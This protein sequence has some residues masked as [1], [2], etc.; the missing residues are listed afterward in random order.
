MGWWYRI[1]AQCRLLPS[2]P[3][4]ICPTDCMEFDWQPEDSNHL[5]HFSQFQTWVWQWTSERM[6]TVSWGKPASWLSIL[7]RWFRSYPSRCWGHALFSAWAWQDAYQYQLVFL[8]SL[9][10]CSPPRRSQFPSQISVWK[11]FHYPPKQSMTKSAQLFRQSSPSMQ[12]QNS[13]KRTIQAKVSLHQFVYHFLL[14][15]TWICWR[16]RNSLLLLLDGPV[17]CIV[18][19]KKKIL[20]LLILN[21][22]HAYGNFFFFSFSFLSWLQKQ[23]KSIYLFSCWFCD[24]SMIWQH[25]LVAIF[26][27]CGNL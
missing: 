3:D 10:Y 21:C 23:D 7:F 25:P 14:R 18:S 22:T 11:R 13:S 17:L 1:S 26:G 15:F 12:I 2:P 19:K 8:P 4:K 27:N 24:L 9:G 5:S 16:Y 20:P 6:F